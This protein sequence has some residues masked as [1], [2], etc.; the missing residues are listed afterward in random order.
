MRAEMAGHALWR[1]LQGPIVAYDRLL[2]VAR[3]APQLAFEQVTA[4]QRRILGQRLV[5]APFGVVVLAQ[6]GEDLGEADHRSRVIGAE[7]GS[8]RQGV[9]GVLRS[10]QAEQR[11]ASENRGVGGALRS[12]QGAIEIFQD[13]LEA[14]LK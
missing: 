12:R 5:D 11:F 13:L 6:G 2:R 8:A 10:L 4:N 7:R 9:G 3:R 1:Q 14:A